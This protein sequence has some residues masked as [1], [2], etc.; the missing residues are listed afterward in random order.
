MTANSSSSPQ[1]HPQSPRRP[2]QLPFR[3][4]LLLILIGILLASCAPA[5][6]SDP[7]AVVQAAYDRLN[8]DDVDGYMKFLSDDAVVVDSTGRLEGSEAIRDNLTLTWVPLDFR[9]ELSE[10][11]SD[12]NEVTYTIKL[13]EGDRLVDTQDDGLTIVVDGKDHF[14][15]HGEIS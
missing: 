8:Q 2:P 12:G 1:E 9:F 5:Q 11:S 6:P 7:V 14:R 13:Y 4:G 10:L 3:S 15:W